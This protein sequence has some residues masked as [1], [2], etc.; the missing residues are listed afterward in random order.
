MPRRPTVL[1]MRLRRNPKLDLIQSI[2][3]FA[4]CTAKELAEVSA[5]ADEID[6]PAGDHVV[7]EHGVGR[8]FVVVIDGTA[9]VSR[10]GTVIDSIGPGEWFGEVALITGQPRNAEIVATTSLHAFIIEGHRFTQLLH[11][12]PSI[13]EKVQAKL[14]E[15]QPRG[16][17]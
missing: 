11:D 8:E 16:D 5:I 7:T 13:A 15:H 12:S 9:T 14:A 17:A 4:D 1:G 3:L 6:L 2:P 10:D